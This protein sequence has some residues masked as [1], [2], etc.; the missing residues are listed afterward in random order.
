MNERKEARKQGKSASLFSCEPCEADRR[1]HHHHT[2]LLRHP[3]LPSSLSEHCQWILN[4]IHVRVTL[5]PFEEPGAGWVY[6]YGTREEKEEISTSITRQDGREEAAAGRKVSSF[7][8]SLDAAMPFRLDAFSASAVTKK[9]KRKKKKEEEDRNSLSAGQ[10]GW[11]FSLFFSLSED[12]PRPRPRTRQ[13]SYIFISHV[14]TCCCCCCC[15]CAHWARG[16]AKRSKGRVVVV[17]HLN[18]NEIKKGRKKR[19]GKRKELVDSFVLAAHCIAW[20]ICHGNVQT[21]IKH[22]VLCSA[23]PP[24]SISL[25]QVAQLFACLHTVDVC[26]YSPCIIRK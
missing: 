20:R 7:A 21:P 19:E 1:W 24:S 14:I 26:L 13:C 16:E 11:G 10:D 12:T 2:T 9:K 25:V 3:I 6:C 8:R 22:D 5:Y 23:A 18:K 17:V 4:V 15:V